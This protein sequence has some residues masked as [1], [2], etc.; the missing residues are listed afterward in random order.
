MF[1]AEGSQAVSWG[2]ADLSPTAHSIT[3][4][5]VHGQQGGCPPGGP[6]GGDE[7]SAL[8]AWADWGGLLEEVTWS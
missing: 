7:S 6:G 3:C 5:Q 1:R 4:F 8:S 2:A